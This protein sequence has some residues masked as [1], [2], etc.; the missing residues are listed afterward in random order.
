MCIRACYYGNDGRLFV[1]AGERAKGE[2]E[3]SYGWN[4]YV[5][6]LGEAQRLELELDRIIPVEGDERTLGLMVRSIEAFSDAESFNNLDI[7]MKNKALNEREFL[8]GKT[9]LESYPTHL[10]IDVEDRCNIVPRCV[11]CNWR[12]KSDRVD[13]YHYLALCQKRR[14]YR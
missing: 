4:T 5:L 14:S 2:I 9:R 1:R 6:D 11:Y 8:S 7:L 13:D 3:L 10:R 12:G